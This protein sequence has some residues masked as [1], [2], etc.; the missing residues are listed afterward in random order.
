MYNQTEA[1]LSQYEIEVKQT[2]KG[3]GS[4]ICDTD[5]GKKMLVAFRGS[6]ERGEALAQYL[7]FLQEAGFVV[8]QIFPNK[9]EKAVTVD[10]ISGERFILKSFL[11][12]AEVEPSNKEEIRVGA[13]LLGEYHVCS[14]KILP[15]NL[16]PIFTETNTSVLDTKNRHYRELIKI[17][18]HIGV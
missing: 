8:E 10:E 1:I 4:Y 17:R 9:E 16:P 7:K 3:R 11:E 14:K 12:G 15:Q 5:K 18:N 2:T 6:P 13:R